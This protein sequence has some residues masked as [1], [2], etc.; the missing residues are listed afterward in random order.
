MPPLA[1]IVELDPHPEH[2]DELLRRLRTSSR[3]S[4]GG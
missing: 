2:R 1:I 4:C 3:N